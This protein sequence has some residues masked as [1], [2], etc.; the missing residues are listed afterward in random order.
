MAS[1]GQQTSTEVAS[2]NP[3]KKRKK[4]K[5]YEI[6]LSTDALRKLDSNAIKTNPKGSFDKL[7]IG[8]RFN[9]LAAEPPSA[10]GPQTGRPIAEVTG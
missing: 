1:L 6:M 2:L 10:E 8:F 5:S 4:K 3:P 7:R 9:R